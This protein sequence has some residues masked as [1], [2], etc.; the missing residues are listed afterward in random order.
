LGTRPI[1]AITRSGL[2]GTGVEQLA[3][4]AELRIWE[5]NRG[6]S[7]AEL[8][9]FIGDADALLSM[10]QDRI[11][12]ALLADT[13]NLAIV[14]QASMGHDNLDLAALTA[15]GI[16]ASNTPGVLQETTADFT[17][18]LILAACRRVTEADRYVR[19]GEW[20]DVRF[21]LLLGMDL[22]GATLGVIGYGQIGRAVAR[23]SVGFDM[24]VI[25]HDPFAASDD[26]STAVELD[27]LLATADVVSI[28]TVLDD[29]TTHLISDRELS[30]MK[31][32]AVLVNAARGPIV[33]ERALVRA[34]AREEIW[35]AALDVFEEEPIGSDHPLLAHP[36]CVVAPHLG[37][38]SHAT[39][40]H[41]VDIAVH[42]IVEGLAGRPL[43]NILNPAV[44]AR[45]LAR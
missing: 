15:A 1:V 6:P 26:L 33:D 9:S 44:E 5:D 25:H 43:P 13:P 39:R 22:H 27:V 34:L 10:S 28:H 8:A 7:A 21:D 19:Q 23:R 32:T 37:S 12:A 41:M 2:P 11:D 4:V 18:S 16:P 30:L 24:T 36:R 29:R 42:N 3:E 35:A 45:P 14:G 31:S 20:T 40:A 17:W 38:A